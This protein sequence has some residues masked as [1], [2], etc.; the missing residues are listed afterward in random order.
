MPKAFV[1]V[2]ERTLLAHQRTALR[3]S[4]VEQVHLVIGHNAERV[5]RHPDTEGLVLWE[6][7]EFARTNMVATLL[8]AEGPLDGTSDLVIAYGD[9]VYEP[10]LLAALG[11]VHAPIGVVVDVR[12][13]D[14]WQARMDDPLADAETLR[15]TPDGRLVELGARP[16]GYH[17]IE[18][19]YIGLIRVRSDA[20]PTLVATARR[21]VAADPNVFMTALLQQLIDDGLHVQAAQVE[22]GWLEFDR[23]EDLDVDFDRFWAPVDS[24]RG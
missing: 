8:C 12:W 10:R 11:D 22:N 2:R 7:V 13:R 1:P 21:L 9:I 6:N 4:G 23:P 24:D 19:Q 18:G 3:S 16:T 15:M 17:D 20:I 5:R 14:Y